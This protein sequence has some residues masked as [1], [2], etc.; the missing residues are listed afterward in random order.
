M[1]FITDLM[2]ISGCCVTLDN[3]LSYIFKQKSE[4]ILLNFLFQVVNFEF[5]PSTSNIPRKKAPSS[6]RARIEHVLGSDGTSSGNT[7]THPLDAAQCCD[8]RGLQKSVV[9]VTSAVRADSALRGLFQVSFSS[10]SESKLLL[11]TVRFGQ[12]TT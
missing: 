1:K 8:V 7:P 11:M 4:K 9:D 6:L 2:I 10:P 3:I 12:T 5:S